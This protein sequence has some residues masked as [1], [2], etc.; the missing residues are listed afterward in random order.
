MEEILFKLAFVLYFIAAIMGICGILKGGKGSSKIIHLFVGSG[1]LMHTANIVYRYVA[2]GHLPAVGMHEASSF[3]AWCI[4]LLFFFLKYRYQIG[5]MGSFILPIVSI[6]MLIAL[7]SPGEMR[8]LSP[9]LQDYWLE[10]HTLLAFL[11]Y[12]AFA[13][14]FGIGIMYLIQEYYL[15]S[16]HP[17]ELFQRLPSLQVLDEINYRLIVIGFPLFTLA[18]IAGAIGAEAAW[19]AYWRWDPK[20]ILALIIWGVY[21][22]ALFVRLAIGWKGRKIA[23]LSIAGF[24]TVLFAFFGADLFLK[25]IHTFS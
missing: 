12:A 11:S 19:G 6:L 1:F 23:A 15:K 16:R 2:L 20:E 17:R 5:I 3:F 7:I 4:V 25:S 8:P 21:A 18:I 22:L 9:I 14:A 13:V 10:V 24:S